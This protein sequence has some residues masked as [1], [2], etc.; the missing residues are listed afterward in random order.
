M[1]DSDPQNKPLFDVLTP[2]GFRVHVAQKYWDVITSVKHPVMSGREKQVIEVLQNPN[3]IRQSKRDDAVYLF[4]RLERP[5]RWL[6][7]VAKRMEADGFL[8]TVYPTDAVKEGETIW[9]Q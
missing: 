4:Y 1:S 7:A 9:T 8:I 3:E 2:L 5:G 6:C